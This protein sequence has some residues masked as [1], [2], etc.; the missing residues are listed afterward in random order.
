LI[1]GSSSSA[2]LNS[3]AVAS[4]VTDRVPATDGK[5]PPTGLGPVGDRFSAPLHDPMMSAVLER[6]IRELSVRSVMARPLRKR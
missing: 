1:G 5:P 3:G 2:A 4:S 6:A